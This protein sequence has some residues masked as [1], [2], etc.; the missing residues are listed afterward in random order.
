MVGD[1]NLFLM[2][3][4]VETKSTGLAST[5]EVEVMIAGRNRTCFNFFLIAGYMSNM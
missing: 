4:P 5:A 2:K 1:V 3:E